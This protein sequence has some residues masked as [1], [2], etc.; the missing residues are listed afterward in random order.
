METDFH[1]HELQRIVEE[2]LCF[3][4]SYDIY[5]EWL[6]ALKMRINDLILKDFEKLVMILYHLDVD[7]LK[8]KK[9]LM[10]FPGSDAGE[11]IGELII[12]RQL[13]KIKTREA[14][15]RDQADIDENEKW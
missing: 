3:T 10:D 4:G 1:Q 12:E 6:S 7:E 9:L 14:F 2:K 15:R 11:I 8:M 13:Q 5:E